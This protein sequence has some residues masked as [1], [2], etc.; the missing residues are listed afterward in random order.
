MIAKY[1]SMLMVKRIATEYP[2]VVVYRSPTITHIVR[3]NNQDP[4][5]TDGIPNTAHMIPV[6]KSMTASVISRIR[7]GELVFFSFGKIIKLTMFPEI[8]RVDDNMTITLLNPIAVML[9]ASNSSVFVE[10]IVSPDF[11]DSAMKTLIDI[12]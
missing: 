12:N 11:S 5:V 6:I 8:I 10:F 7:V 4:V 3:P 1:R 9:K 2:T